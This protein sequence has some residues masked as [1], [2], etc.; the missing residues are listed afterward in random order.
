MSSNISLR[1][2]ARA[3]NDATVADDARTDRLAVRNAAL[4]AA[5]KDGHTIRA[6]AEA[7]ELSP[8]TVS[9]A[10]GRPS[11]RGKVTS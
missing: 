4:L 11:E 2:A 7:C 8:E 9:K 6:I 10:C 3:S 1:R 5:Y